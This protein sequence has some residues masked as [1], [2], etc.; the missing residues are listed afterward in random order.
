MRIKN[1]IR[2]EIE[3]AAK[4]LKIVVNP[5]FTI[6]TPKNIEFGDFS[7]NI[8]L[9]SAKQNKQTPMELAELINTKFKRNKNFS[10]VTVAKPG[11][12]NFTISRSL[13]VEIIEE[14]LSAGTEYG[15]S[16]YGNETKVLLEF[17]SANPTGPL[18]IVSAR[19]AAFGDTIYRVMSY[20]GFLPTREFYINDA[21]NQVEILAE[22]IE[23]RF[24][25]ILGERIGEMPDEAYHGEYIR[26][27]AAR[28]N[29]VEGSRILHMNEIE[30]LEKIKRFALDEIHEMQVESLE[31]FDVEFDSWISEKAIRAT[32]IIE[33]VLSYL[34]EAKVTYEKEDAIWFMATK[35]DDEKD[36]VLLKADGLPTYFVPDIAYHTTKYHR[37]FDVII[38]VL[39]PDHHGYIQRLIAALKALKYDETKM[40]FI[41]LQQVNLFN[42]GEKIKMSKRLGKIV[43]MD[44]LIEEVGKDAARFFFIDRKPASHLNFDLELAKKQSAENPVYYCQYA[45]ARICSVLEKSQSLPFDTSEI[46]YSKLKKLNKQDEFQ[47]IKKLQEFE[48]VLI[49]VADQREPHRLTEYLKE[50]SGMFHKYYHDFNILNKRTKDTTLARIYLIMA[51]KNVLNIAFDLIGVGAPEK[52]QKKNEKNTCC[53]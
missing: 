20:L 49:N 36:R 50:L 37:E 12:L 42:E 51:I 25:E 4:A 30:R 47:L 18:N 43:T 26:E 15:K 34:Y 52:M 16:N 39:G 45:Y 28:L 40:E 22:S 6:E 24:R 48:E 2:H 19:A 17:V 38:D 10:A 21:G 3:K 33:E 44:E 31:K 14:I 11:F 46:D 32:G 41:I 13:Y 27:L 23:L 29:T 1:I 35:F 7:S 8:A 9:V 53:L 5:I